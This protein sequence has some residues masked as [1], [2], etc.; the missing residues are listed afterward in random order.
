MNT[1]LV[2]HSK[3]F[4]KF[5][6]KLTECTRVAVCGRPFVLVGKL[7]DWLRSQ[8]TPDFTHIQLQ[9]GSAYQTRS[10]PNLP[11][12]LDIFDPGD[13]CCLL[14]FCILRTIGH[15]NL[16]H[17]FAEEGKSDVQLP[18]SPA[19]VGSI[20]R[21]ANA[22]D[23]AA[24]FCEEQHRFKPAKFKFRNHA[25]WNQD[26][27][28][29]IYSKTP[30]NE[31]GTAHLWLID[32]P[33]EFVEESLRIQLSKR[34]RFN[35]A[36]PDSDPDWVRTPLQLCPTPTS[37]LSTSAMISPFFHYFEVPLTTHSVT[38]LRSKLL[39]PRILTRQSL[40]TKRKHSSA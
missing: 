11:F 8:A 23:L 9:V 19:D 27:V 26:V 32:V 31:G 7:Q 37:L 3:T 30:I 22:S 20:F 39:R 2:D 14:I 34:S 21:T 25:K 5:N 33:E 4:Q 38:N 18:L 24:K 16:I 10:R 13:E 6:D 15:G 36:T 29:P 40:T 35:A 1:P 17:L 28:I 12:G